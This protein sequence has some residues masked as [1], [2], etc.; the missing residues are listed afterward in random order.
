MNWCQVEDDVKTSHPNWVYNGMVAGTILRPGDKVG[1]KF[2][3]ELSRLRLTSKELCCVPKERG[4]PPV[5]GSEGERTA[6]PTGKL[7]REYMA[8]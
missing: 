1:Q 3:E 5:T 6:A 7:G 2:P 4:R 8:H